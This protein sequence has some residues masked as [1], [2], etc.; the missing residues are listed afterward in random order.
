ML[1]AFGSR[2][3]VLDIVQTSDQARSEIKAHRALLRSWCSIG[4]LDRG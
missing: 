2:E 1:L 3:H 4:F